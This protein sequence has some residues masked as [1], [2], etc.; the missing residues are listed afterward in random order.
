M[1]TCIQTKIYIQ[2]AHAIYAHIRGAEAKK[3]YASILMT[4]SKLGQIVWTGCMKDKWRY[5]PQSGRRDKVNDISVSKV[6]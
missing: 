1:G 5:P 2:H 3:N 4:S 6:T